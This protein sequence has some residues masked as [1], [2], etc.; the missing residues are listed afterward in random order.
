MRRG[1]HHS[2]EVRARI[3]A[4]LADPEVRARR[5]AAQRKACA[6]PEV[7]ARRSAAQRKAWADP[8]VRARR[9]AAQKRNSK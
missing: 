3:S 4:A 1:T 7:R 6:D 9:S 2:V 5:S 8:E